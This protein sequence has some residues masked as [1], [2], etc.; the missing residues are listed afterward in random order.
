MRRPRLRSILRTG[1]FAL[2]AH[3]GQLLGV[4]FVAQSWIV[5][6]CG[7]ALILLAGVVDG[8]LLLPGRDV[9]LLEHPGI[10]ALL[11][12]QIGLPIAVRSSF[13]SLLRTRGSI[14]GFAPSPA[15]LAAT[16][17]RPVVRFVQLATAESRVVATLFFSF[18]LAAFVW[19][20]YQNQ[21]PRIVVPFDFWDST[22]FP[23]GFWTT[24]LFKLY[25]LVWLLPFVAL[26]HVA[27]ITVTLRL[28]RAARLRGTL[29][30]APFHSDGA[31]GLGFVP[32]LVTTPAIVTLL[33][34]SLPLAAAFQV[35]RAADVTPIMGLAVVL[36]VV[37]IAYVL[38][39]LYLRT[40]IVAMKRE[41]L[42]R[43]RALQDNY[44]Q[45][46]VGG[47]GVRASALREGNDALDYFDKVCLRVESISDYPHLQRLMSYAGVAL[48]PSALSM[49]LRLYDQL[50]P[51][52]RPLL[53]HR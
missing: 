18:G 23:C 45:K 22:T 24:R 2:H 31:G 17:V 42:A 29:K 40:D 7:A 4:G 11:G 51:V 35:H 39:I 20:T 46:I 9:G 50:N 6:G 12:L 49:L 38:P 30:L 21:Q 34:V 44:Y 41:L 53:E 13:V 19:N 8:S 15:P 47:S 16:V 10:W 48:M 27:L 5:G 37:G 28:I 25:L 32:G 36:S 33:I 43:L 26:V 3:I 14:R 52:V 1:G